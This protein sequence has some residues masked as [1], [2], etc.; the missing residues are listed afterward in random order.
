[1]NIFSEIDLT[2]LLFNLIPTFIHQFNV[3][4]QK[5]AMMKNIMI[6]S[7]CTVFFK[8][9]ILSESSL[10][11][12]ILFTTF[13]IAFHFNWYMYIIL[14]YLFPFSLHFIVTEILEAK[15]VE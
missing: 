15:S 13:S 1:M 8:Y 9:Q 3:S 4:E 2:D 10:H 7:I 5:V 14:I 6:M 11:M 12:Y